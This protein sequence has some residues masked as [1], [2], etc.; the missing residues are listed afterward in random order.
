MA[1]R[2]PA[3]GYSPNADVSLEAKALLAERPEPV[4]LAIRDAIRLVNDHVYSRKMPKHFI[5][6]FI[7]G[8][9]CVDD[10][11]VLRGVR[12]FIDKEFYK[13]NRNL[14]YLGGI[15]R[16]LH[17]TKESQKNAEKNLHGLNP[18]EIKKEK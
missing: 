4:E 5:S 1:W 13:L 3:C 14:A 15:I 2:C 12:L 18:P 9:D 17:Q 6:Q 16:N 11:D 7:Y 10:G 8:V